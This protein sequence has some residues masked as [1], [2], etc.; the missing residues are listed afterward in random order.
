M[1]FRPLRPLKETL[2][3]Q[4]SRISFNNDDRYLINGTQLRI[5]IF[6]VHYAVEL[7]ENCDADNTTAMTELGLAEDFL[8]GITEK[9]KLGRSPSGFGDDL[10]DFKNLFASWIGKTEED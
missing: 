1:T 5:F 7:H 10:R 4:L 9:Q 8:I 2:E 6:A 3:S